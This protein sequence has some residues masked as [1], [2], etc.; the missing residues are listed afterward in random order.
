M[1]PMLY[2]FYIVLGIAS[3]KMVILLA[4]CKGNFSNLTYAITAF[5]SVLV[6]GK[7]PPTEIKTSI[8]KEHSK[9]NADLI[10]PLYLLQREARLIDFLLEDISSAP[11]DLVGAGVREV[12]AKCRKYL[13]EKLTLQPII[14]KEEGSKVSIEEGFNPNK[15]MLT[16]FLE[17]L[18]PYNGVLKHQ[19]WDVLS[20]Q[21]PEVTESFRKN[22]VLVQAELEIP[23]K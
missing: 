11:D 6:R 7:T 3:M 8:S 4:L 5:F 2:A 9:V 15:I 13:L 23:Q 10:W 19:G 20:S 22:P 12:H 14:S 18:P 16:G 1:E 21:I 17:G